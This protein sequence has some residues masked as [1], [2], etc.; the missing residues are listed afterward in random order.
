MHKK[1]QTKKRQLDEGFRIKTSNRYTELEN[2]EPLPYIEENQM[3]SKRQPKRKK[4]DMEENKAVEGRQAVQKR[5]TN[6][7]K[8]KTMKRM[9]KNAKQLENSMSLLKLPKDHNFLQK[10][11]PKFFWERC[12]CRKRTCRLTIRKAVARVEWTGVWL[13]HRDDREDSPNYDDNLL[14]ESAFN[15]LS[16]RQLEKRKKSQEERLQIHVM[17]SEKQAINIEDETTNNKNV[18]EP[19]GE[20]NAG[21]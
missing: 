14:I 20:G 9:K 15:N 4:R 8:N 21:G 19:N 16:N 1:W 10:E 3:Q 11:F 12:I 13:E 17:H 6:E 7:T 2:A 5:T 18:C